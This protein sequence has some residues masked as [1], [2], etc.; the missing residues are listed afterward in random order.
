MLALIAHW[1]PE[2]GKGKPSAPTAAHQ[3][4]TPRLLRLV[5]LAEA[6]AVSAADAEGSLSDSIAQQVDC[7]RGRLA[8]CICTCH[9]TL[10][11]ASLDPAK[12]M[13][14]LPVPNLSG[15]RQRHCCHGC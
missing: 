9:G 11:G 13:V 15:V 3:D 7:V 1:L 8:A 5:E 2:A 10:T 14:L 4:L 12:V 6:E